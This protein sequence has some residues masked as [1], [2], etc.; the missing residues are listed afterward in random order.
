MAIDHQLMHHP[1]HRHF[2]STPH[3]NAVHSAHQPSPHDVQSHLLSVASA[4]QA[5]QQLEQEIK[6]KRRRKRWVPNRD[7]QAKRER[8]GKEGS[9][10]RNRYDNNNFTFHDLAMLDP[11][12]LPMPG[13]PS[14]F[15]RFHFTCQVV[16][17]ILMVLGEEDDRVELAIE[18]LQNN[19]RGEGKKE[20]RKE[21]SKK[22]EQKVERK[23]ATGEKAE[24]AEKMEEKK[25]KEKT[26]NIKQRMGKERNS[27]K[28]R[29]ED[30]VEEREEKEQKGIRR[31]NQE[32]G[33]RKG[34]QSRMEGQREARERREDPGREDG[35]RIAQLGS[36]LTDLH[37]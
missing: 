20:K 34:T 17:R 36:L 26:E 35:Y 24:K 8:P 32:S 33:A 28:D 18:K 22:D 11:H 21:K 31:E 29:D 37:L 12:D 14:A 27:E 3:A 19:S 23:K 10:R 7:S 4:S 16:M 6:E 2:F 5:E 9:R 30:E 1:F 13:Y 25:K 15:P